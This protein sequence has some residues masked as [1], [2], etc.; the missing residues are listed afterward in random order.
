MKIKN[1]DIEINEAM[2]FAN[3]DNI[4]LKRRSNNMLLSDYQLMILERNNFNYEKYS[5]IRKLLFDIENY[6]EENYDDELDLVSSQLAEFIYYYDTKKWEDYSHFFKYLFSLFDY[7]ILDR[8]MVF[9]LFFLFGKLF[10]CCF[11]MGE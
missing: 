11:H 6:L 3:N 9:F 2:D 10:Y 8:L 5:N 7:M 4:L 1:M